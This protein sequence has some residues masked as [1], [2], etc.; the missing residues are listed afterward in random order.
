MLFLMLCRVG[1]RQ[2]ATGQAG[3]LCRVLFG[4]NRA[5]PKTNAHPTPFITPPATPSG[6]RAFIC[7]IRCLSFR[8]RA[9]TLS[10]P[11][12]CSFASPQRSSPPASGGCWCASAASGD[13][14]AGSRQLFFPF[15]AG[16]VCGVLVR[17]PSNPRPKNVCTHA[18]N[19]TLLKNKHSSSARWPIARLAF[20]RSSSRRRPS[21]RAWSRPRKR[22]WPRLPPRAATS[23]AP[24][25]RARATCIYARARE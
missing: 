1:S 4:V 23:S 14:E 11:R 8:A 22:R 13:Q 24:R 5:K 3:F 10:R 25:R 7:T 16:F 6:R 17:C 18:Q 9:P 21:R 2:S 19:K 15:R 20:T 12:R